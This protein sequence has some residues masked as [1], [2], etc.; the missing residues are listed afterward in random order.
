MAASNL[1]YICF[2]QLP[3]LAV[4]DSKC[5]IQGGPKNWTICRDRGEVYFSENFFVKFP[6]VNEIFGVKNLWALS[7]KT[8][9]GNGREEPDVGRGR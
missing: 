3:V 6:R 5:I 1:L 8:G 7:S 4:F 2:R 9:T